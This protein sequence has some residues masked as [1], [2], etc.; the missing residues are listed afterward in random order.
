MSK[1]LY[2]DKFPLTNLSMKEHVKVQFK[3]LVAL[4]KIRMHK[5]MFL[6]QYAILYVLVG[7]G[8]GSLVD[9]IFPEYNP[10]KKNSEIIKEIVFQTAVNA[11][12]LFYA[13]KVVM[14]CPYL[15]NFDNSFSHSHAQQMRGFHGTIMLTIAFIATQT[16]YLKK[17]QHISKN[18]IIKNLKNKED[19]TAPVVEVRQD[20][21]RPTKETVL[22]NRSTPIQTKSIN[23]SLLHQQQAPAVDQ[24]NYNENSHKFAQM[25]MNTGT[26]NNLQ[27]ANNQQA[28]FQSSNSIEAQNMMNTFAEPPIMASNTLGSAFGGNFATLDNDYQQIKNAAYM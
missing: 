1:S 17:I 14:L 13:R 10:D 18:T 9:N 11:V 6:V 25:A 3:K 19:D 21:G 4:D 20:P 16:S 24:T 12:A 26:I 28:T 7:L 2:V 22:Q 15:F 8:A 27:S 23:T 5:L